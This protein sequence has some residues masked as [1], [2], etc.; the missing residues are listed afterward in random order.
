MVGGDAGGRE[1]EAQIGMSLNS[2]GE[3]KLGFGSF[4]PESG[5][6]IGHG[7][8]LCSVKGPQPD[9]GCFVGVP[10]LSCPFAPWPLSHTSVVPSPRGNLKR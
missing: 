9:P 4:E 1:E 6:V 5:P 7:C 10:Y 2:F 3:I 8:T